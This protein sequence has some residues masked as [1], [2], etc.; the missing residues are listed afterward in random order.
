MRLHIIT[1]FVLAGLL[2]AS[3]ANAQTGVRPDVVPELNAI[4]RGDVRVTPDRA[5]VLISVETHA[6]SAAAASSANSDIT[7]LTIKAV[8]ANTT[9]QDL[10]TTQSY[11][12]I[13]DYQKGKPS[14][15]GARNTVR[16][17][18]RD[19]SR[20][21][22]IIDAALTAGAT[23]ISQVQ[24]SSSLTPDAR[25]RAMKLAVAEARLDAE[26]M[27]EAAGGTVGRL[28]SLTSFSSGGVAQGR[29]NEMAMVSLRAAS[30]EYTPP[31]MIPD[32]LTITG[33]ANVKW[34]FI[35]RKAP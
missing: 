25:R 14:G 22:K 26:A 27:A 20:L 28:L 15:F 18:V 8:K 3:G 17:E 34:E 10:V 9:V 32:E 12:V 7:A 11:S 24:F 16:V 29:L 5:T 31:P 1:P 21:G 19:I 23:Q 35:P 33:S 2:A 30:A 4:G 13:P 6:S